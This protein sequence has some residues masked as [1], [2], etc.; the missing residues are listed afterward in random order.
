MKNRVLASI[1]ILSWIVLPCL[2]S[3]NPENNPDDN[4]Q[5]V[6]EWV[7]PVPGKYTFVSPEGHPWKPGDVI[8]VHGSYAPAAVNVT[9]DATNISADGKKA[10][11]QLSGKLFDYPVKPDGLYAAYPADKVSFDSDLIGET[12]QFKN[13]DYEIFAAYLAD[14]G[15]VFKSFTS[16]LSLSVEGDY[17]C[18][19]LTGAG[20][21]D[22]VFKSCDVTCSTN[23]EGVLRPTKGTQDEIERTFEGGQITL[24]FP[25]IMSLKSGFVL[26]FGK[27][28]NY[29]MMY[30]NT[31]NVK[32][33]RGQTLNLGKITGSLVP[34]DGYIPRMPTLSKPTKI[35]VNVEELSG[36]CLQ[37]DGSALWGVGD[38]G[39]LAKVSFEG[40]VQNIK[41]FSTDL[42][43][44]TRNPNTGDLLVCIEGSQKVAKISAPE[45]TKR[46]DLFVVQD[47]VDGKFGNSGLEGITYYKDDVIYVGSQAGPY[48]WKFTLDGQ[49]KERINLKDVTST[50]KET[51]D[52]CYDPVNDWLWVADSEAHKLFVFTGDAH[53][54]VG[55]IALATTQNEES[56]CV[57]YA[58]GCIW[59][60]DDDDN[61]PAVYRY[62]IVK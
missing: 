52:L 20:K 30:K 12:I 14:G 32:I 42:E 37:E 58:H 47:A 54:L 11:V 53:R 39:Q 26:Y 13:P 59:V 60:G 23:D 19:Y 16:T 3:C 7:A 56:V 10:T 9:L 5:P 57:D 36:I 43:G 28:G 2:I 40:N 49:M 55:K 61:Q 18:F 29:S 51:A 22:L 44:I 50:I 34:F 24:H 1:L 46:T 17:N 48:L 31:D 38:Q 33:V 4:G 8:N 27:D 35:N 62:D 6:D 41:D 45:F 15:F 25:G 21:E